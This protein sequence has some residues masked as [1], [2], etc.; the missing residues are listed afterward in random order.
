V[1]KELLKRC[2]PFLSD[3][4]PVPPLNLIRDLDIGIKNMTKTPLEIALLR[5]DG[6]DKRVA[7]EKLRETAN[8][9]KSRD[10]GLFE[11]Y[12]ALVEMIT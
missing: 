5:C 10:T 9:Y 12:S 8:Y 1:T 7:R 4:Q 2:R 3:Y 11:I 6:D